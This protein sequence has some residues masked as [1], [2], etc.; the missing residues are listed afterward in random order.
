MRKLLKLGLLPIFLTLGVEA[1]ELSKDKL[2]QTRAFELEANSVTKLVEKQKE[3]LK[4]IYEVSKRGDKK[5]LKK[6]ISLF[7]K[8]LNGLIEGDVDLALIGTT[9][10]DILKQLNI[11]KKEWEYFKKDIKNSNSK[12]AEERYNPLVKNIDKTIGMYQKIN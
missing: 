5:T 7:D 10:K 8:T 1:S 6:D 3:L 4:K 11:V 2:E 9:D 12:R